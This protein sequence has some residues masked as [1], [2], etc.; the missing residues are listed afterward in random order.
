MLSLC[1]T[2]HY[3]SSH[4]SIYYLLLSVDAMQIS[5]KYFWR[6]TK[7]FKDSHLNKNNLKKDALNISILWDIYTKHANIRILYNRQHLHFLYT[8]TLIDLLLLETLKLF[9]VSFEDDGSPWC[10]TAC[11]AAGL[12][13]VTNQDSDCNHRFPCSKLLQRLLLTTVSS[14][15]TVLLIRSEFI[16]INNR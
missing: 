13:Y 3:E 11:E 4:P 8:W 7:Y 16:G 2:L 1:V 14:K 15:W 5:F 6:H 9:F 12:D 10:C